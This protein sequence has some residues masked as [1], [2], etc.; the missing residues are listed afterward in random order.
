LSV[1]RRAVTAGLAYFAVVFATGFALG[2]IRERFARP[3]L[4]ARAAEMAEIPLMIGVAILAAL[5][6]VTRYALSRRTARLL[7]G[8]LALLLLVAGELIVA[9]IVRDLD[10]DEYLASR[11][12]VVFPAYLGA[13]ALF[14]LMPALVRTRRA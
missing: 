11:D 1:W 8:L 10:W 9:A 14:A 13:L 5:W 12:P 6:V 4:G 7:A 2:V 3:L